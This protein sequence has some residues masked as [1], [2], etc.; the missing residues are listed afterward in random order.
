MLALGETEGLG[1]TEG[2]SDELGLREAL[3][4]TEGDSELEGDTDALGERLALGESEG[5]TED[6]GLPRLSACTKPR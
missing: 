4:E 2:D 3:G 6:D 1:L 5:E